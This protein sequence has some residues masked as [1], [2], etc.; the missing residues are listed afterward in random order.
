AVFLHDTPSQ[1]LFARTGRNFS[2]GCVRV[3]AALALA[4][5]LLA[6]LPAAEQERVAQLLASGQTHEIPLPGGPRLI[7]GYWTAE[8][9]SNGQVLLLPDPYRFD[10]DLLAA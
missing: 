1:H 6:D 3:E 10:P 9:G 4:D 5:L 8:A 7:L 2:S